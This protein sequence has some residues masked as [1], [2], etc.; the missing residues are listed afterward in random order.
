MTT[1]NM[2]MLKIYR[3]DN[4]TVDVLDTPSVDEVRKAYVEMEKE[5]INST[6]EKRPFRVPL[7]Q[8]Q[9]FAPNLIMEIKVE[10]ISL[11]DYQQLQNPYYKQMQSEGLTGMMNA[12]FKQRG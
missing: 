7:P 1:E 12:N 5:W 8:L 10:V 3:A 4:H 11:A 2:Y 6:A 9:C